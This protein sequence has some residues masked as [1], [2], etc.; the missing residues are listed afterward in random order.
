MISRDT[1]QICQKGSVS[2]GQ[3]HGEE[4]G[5]GGSAEVRLMAVAVLVLITP[6]PCCFRFGLC[7][8][9]C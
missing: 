6:F 4:G 2:S 9:P 8:C 5:W 1:G 7:P 3:L